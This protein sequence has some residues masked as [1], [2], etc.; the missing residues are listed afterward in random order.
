M[1]TIDDVLASFARDGGRAYGERVTQHAHALQSAALAERD[2]ASP[3]LVAAALLHDIGHFVAKTPDGI[4]DRHEHIGAPVSSTGC[5]GRRSPSRSAFTS[6]PNATSA[7]SNAAISRPCPRPRSRAWRCKAAPSRGTRRRRSR[8][9]TSRTTRCGCAAGTTLPKCPTRRPSR[10]KRMRVCFA[11]SPAEGVTTPRRSA[12]PSRPSAPITASSILA[13][14]RSPNART[15]HQISQAPDRPR[16]GAPHPGR[17][18]GHVGQSA[19]FAGDEARPRAEGGAAQ[20][21]AAGRRGAPHPRR[22]SG[23]PRHA[24]DAATLAATLAPSP[25][26]I[27]RCKIRDPDAIAPA[28]RRIIGRG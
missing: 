19:A 24:G 16:S 25:N 27:G 1:K 9:A 10:S 4:D 6:K 13:L 8:H 11:V 26:W 5:S 23:L 17:M 14:H 22:G 15:H 21:G 7:P 20:R 28:T 2:G 12:L 3:S 18:P